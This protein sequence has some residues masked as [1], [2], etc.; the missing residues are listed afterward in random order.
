MPALAVV[1]ETSSSLS[2][3]YLLEMD[4]FKNNKKEKQK[5]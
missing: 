3:R 4:D 5:C 2:H 1:P